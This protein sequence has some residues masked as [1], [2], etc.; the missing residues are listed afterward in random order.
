MLAILLEIWRR[1]NSE[2]ITWKKSSKSRHACPRYSCNQ[3]TNKSY[4]DHDWSRGDHRYCNCIQE[5]L[6]IQPCIFFYYTSIQEWHNR[7][8]TSKYEST[9]LQKEP[10]DL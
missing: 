10:P 8:T 2:Q 4:G 7:E 5:L 6:F 9:R 1:Y 3:V